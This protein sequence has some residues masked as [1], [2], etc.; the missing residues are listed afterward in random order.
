[1]AIYY[2]CTYTCTFPFLSAKTTPN[3]LVWQGNNFDSKDLSCND[4]Y[5]VF[6]G[7]IEMTTEL[8]LD[9]ILS[10]LETFL[11]SLL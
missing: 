9:L 8:I 5:I 2:A 3:C 10:S 6:L 7:E 1:M 11:Y 4:N